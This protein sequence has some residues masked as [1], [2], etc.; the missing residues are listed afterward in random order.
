ME[1]TNNLVRKL[2][3][4]LR[5]AD[6]PVPVY[7]QAA[8]DAAWGVAGDPNIPWVSTG[9]SHLEKTLSQVKANTRISLISLASLTWIDEKTNKTK[10]KMAEQMQT[11]IGKVVNIFCGPF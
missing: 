8:P 11:H 6:K 5:D 2:T 3:Y 1:A 7:I 4:F 9:L 10:H